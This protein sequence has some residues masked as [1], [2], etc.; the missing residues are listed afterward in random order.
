MT[1]RLSL[2]QGA[3][4]KLGERNLASLTE[5]REPRYVL[6]SVWNREAV[7]RCLQMGQWNFATRAVLLDPDPSVSPNFG[8]KNAYN[9]PD[10]FVLTVAVCADEYFR[11]RFRHYTDENARWWTDLEELYV[12]YVS[13]DSQFGLDFSL[14]PPNFTEFVEYFLATRASRR[15]THTKVDLDTLK[16]EYKDALTLAKGTDAFEQNA[17]QLPSGSWTT[18]RRGRRG[19]GERGDA[20]FSGLVAP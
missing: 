7:K 2:Y 8:Y 12:K 3:L 11:R 13:N 5:D 4:D 15:L 16:Q 1:D 14:W 6:D 9:K 20:D 18:S 17:K 19:S 10:D